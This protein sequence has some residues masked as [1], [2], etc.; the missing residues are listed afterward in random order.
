AT[1]PDGSFQP[2][3]S[4]RRGDIVAPEGAVIAQV[5][6]TVGDDGVSPG[7]FHWIGMARL[8]R[9]G[10]AAFVVVC[11]RRR[12]NQTCLAVFAVEIKASIGVA[13]GGCAE[14]ALLPLDRSGGELDA[15]QAL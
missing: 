13:K 11:F 3:F 1:R 2:F 15:E 4:F 12:I 14:S 6:P 8:I 10:E 5:E 9:G 7:F